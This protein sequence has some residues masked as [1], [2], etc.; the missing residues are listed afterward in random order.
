LK[1]IDLKDGAAEE[2]LEEDST[3]TTQA[4]GGET[5]TPQEAAISAEADTEEA[6]QEEELRRVHFQYDGTPKFSVQVSYDQKKTCAAATY[7]IDDGTAGVPSS[8]P[9]HSFHVLETA[10]AFT[11]TMTL[12][13]EIIPDTIFCDIVSEELELL[14]YNKLGPSDGD[15]EIWAAYKGLS[16]NEK[17]LYERCSFPGGCNL[18]IAHDLDIDAAKLNITEATKFNAHATYPDPDSADSQQ[19]ITGPPEN[20]ADAGY[21]RSLVFEVEGISHTA[22]VLVTGDYALEELQSIALPT[23]KPLLII[24]DPPGGMSF[25]SYQ[26]IQATVVLEAHERSNFAGFDDG[27]VMNWGSAAKGSACV[28][29]GAMKCLLT[30]Q[31]KAGVVVT[32]SGGAS[33]KTAHGN[34]N[35]ENSGDFTTTWS[36]ATSDDPFA[37]GRDSDSFMVP[38]LNVKY[39]EVNEIIWDSGNC[40][41]TKKTEFK[42]NLNYQSNKPAFS[43]V[44][45]YD[46]ENHVLPKFELILADKKAEQD[47][48]NATAPDY[49]RLEKEITA[50]NDGRQGWIQSI[51]DYEATN[52]KTGAELPKVEDCFSGWVT[53]H[54]TVPEEPSMFS[55]T[56]H[57]AALLHESLYNRKEPLNLSQDV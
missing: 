35:K 46:I 55:A 28:G 25:A 37:A 40:I 31:A 49:E 52:N 19:L 51:A 11:V 38:N 44:S 54:D 23:H 50:L 30:E 6:D 20:S 29:I 56:N 57:W 39:M 3:S 16:D 7:I 1:T 45:M 53:S 48:I 24:R 13:R 9:C 12:E 27:L 34:F 21:L 47:G 36:Y 2:D 41:A 10:Q 18:N 32:V 43:F 26:N 17:S 15:K 4:Q 22:C 33:F 5:T 42:M 14:M 8:I